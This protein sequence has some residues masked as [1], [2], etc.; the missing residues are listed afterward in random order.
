MSLPARG[1]WI[2]I[3]AHSRAASPVIGRSP[4]G[5]RG[6]KSQWRELWNNVFQSLPARG[7]WIEIL[8]NMVDEFAKMSLPARGA[9]IEIPT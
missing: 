8:F 9:W 4:H 3:E 7:A 2:E 5:E 1:A 6:L